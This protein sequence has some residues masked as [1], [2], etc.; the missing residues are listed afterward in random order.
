MYRII[1]CLLIVAMLATNVA[2][3][4]DS[5]FTSPV[6]EVLLLVQLDSGQD[7]G[8]CDDF[9]SGWLH[10]QSITLDGSQVDFASARQAVAWTDIPFDSRD[11]DP[12]LRPPQI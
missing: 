2:W 6:G 5:C 3:A 12:P 11:Q 10:L 1:I 8:A 4:E 9:C 7:S